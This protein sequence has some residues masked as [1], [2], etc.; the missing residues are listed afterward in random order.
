MPE[1]QSPAAPATRL[2]LK[3]DVDTK[4]GLLDGT[5]RLADILGELGLKASFFVAMGPDHSGRA[6]KR[7]FRPGFLKKQM[8][9][10]AAAAYGPIT[11]LYGLLLPG[12]IIAR[13]APGLLNRLINEGHEVGLHGW[14]HV[15]WH[16]RVRHLDA[17]RTRRQLELAAGLFREITGM[18][19]ASFASP[20]WQ[21][22]EAALA[23]MAAMGLTHVSCTRGARPFRPL[24]AGRALPL[25]ELPTTMP[26]LD[27]VLGLPQV[28]P[29]NAGRYLAGQVVPGGLNVFTLHGEVEGRQMAPVLRQFLHILLER[30]VVFERL[31][32]AARQAAQAP[33]P[34]EAIAWGT[35]LGRAGE[36]A[37]QPS[38]LARAGA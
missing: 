7:V 11:M 24:V 26:S 18:A 25:I 38:A 6:L 2:V 21:V 33:L 23:A 27:E 37:F 15:Y 29:G 5:R 30:G 17:S 35:V 28:N 34:A 12:P 31:V 8:H 10:G 14:D 3:V 1:P 32:D 22:N 20:G 16:D 9:S 4:V 19:P 36:L 13:S